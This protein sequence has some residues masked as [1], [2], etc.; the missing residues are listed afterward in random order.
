MG[1]SHAGNV[2]V[3]HYWTSGGEAAALAVLQKMMKDEGHTWT[4]FAVAGGGGETAMTVL[5]SRAISGNPPS[6]S[7]IAGP[8][9]SQWGDLG[10][11]AKLDT[12]SA[13]E[14]WDQLLPPV[15]AD[16]HKYQGSY[17]AAPVNVHRI[18]WMWMNKSI[19]DEVNGG[20]VPQTWDEFF[21]YMDKAKQSGYVAFAHGGQDWQDATVFEQV[22]LGV[23]GNE[24]Y[25]QAFVQLDPKALGSDTMTQAFTTFKKLK[26]YMDQGMPGRDWNLSTSMVID[27]KAA[28]QIMGDWAKGEFA[29]AGKQPGKDYVC[30]AVPGTQ[31]A[32]TFNVDAFMMFKQ[33]GQDAQA[34][35][36][37][38]SRLLMSKAFQEEFN[39]KKGS[40]PARPDVSLARFDSC[41][42]QSMA[43]FQASAKSGTLVPSFAHAMAMQPEVS[44]AVYD[45]VTN[46]FNDNDMNAAA[47]TQRL[48]SAIELVK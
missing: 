47:A 12:V 14:R 41:A 1:Q 6:A 5:K 39:L 3:L 26:S 25:Q 27:G 7:M 33:Q 36:Q 32:F 4:D 16:I 9:I 40:I 13:S 18:N 24:W 29:A 28:V 48:V 43:D 19:L 45:V 8:E 10:V 22:A 37:D 23:G 35:Q 2:E 30:A 38:L 20:K 44:G 17:V 42:K 11:L 34:A 21:A 46:F 15:V 31:D